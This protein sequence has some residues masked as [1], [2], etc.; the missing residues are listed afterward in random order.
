MTTSHGMGVMCLPNEIFLM[1]FEKL[2]VIDPITLLGVVP[3]VCRRF[4]GTCSRVQGRFDLTSDWGRLD[5]RGEEMDGP[6]YVP[7]AWAS[8]IRYFPL[9]K[10]AFTFSKTPIHDVLDLK[11]PHLAYSVMKTIASDKKNKLTLVSNA[12]EDTVFHAAAES[13]HRELAIWITKRFLFSLSKIYTPEKVKEYLDTGNVMLNPAISAAALNGSLEFMKILISH[14]AD[15]NIENEDNYTPLHY[16][17]E[18]I[19]YRTSKLLLDNGADI[20]RG[21]SSGY[22]PLHGAVYHGAGPDFL[23]LLYDNGADINRVTD[24]RWITINGVKHEDRD[25]PLHMAGYSGNYEAVVSLLE[26]GADSTV[27]NRIGKTPYDVAF[28]RN[29]FNICELLSNV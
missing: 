17:C 13:D 12:W 14:N 23:E 22:T 24:S 26:R 28:E 1:I 11:N 21:S 15:V 16:C 18:N 20:N 19:N 29:H 5:K 2:L 25:T 27:K 3:R 10:G 9:T 4:M 6:F 7:G 8:M